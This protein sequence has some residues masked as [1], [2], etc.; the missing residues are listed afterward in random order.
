MPRYSAFN[1]NQENGDGVETRGRFFRIGVTVKNRWAAQAVEPVE[2]VDREGRREV[3][4]RWLAEGR[5]RSRRALA[6]AVGVDASVVTRVLKG[7]R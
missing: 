4:A 7:G 1:L 6:R 2:V 3:W 5:Y